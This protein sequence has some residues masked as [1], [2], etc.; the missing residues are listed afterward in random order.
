MPDWRP[1]S[2][3]TAQPREGMVIVLSPPRFR[4]SVP[5]SALVL[6]SVLVFEGGRWTDIE[7][8]EFAPDELPRLEGGYFVELGPL[9]AHDTEVFG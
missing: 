8:F 3:L 9:P 7:G 1:C 2:A 5:A 6:P 4:A